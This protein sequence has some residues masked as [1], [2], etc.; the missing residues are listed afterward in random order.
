MSIK[1]ITALTADRVLVEL[2]VGT[3]ITPAGLVIPPV[4]QEIQAH[5]RV[6]MVGPD[7]KNVAVGD[8]VLVETHAGLEIESGRGTRTVLYV[9][10]DI[11]AVLSDLEA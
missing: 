5:G 9:E 7:V 2:T 8:E 11:Q 4:A 3:Q 1:N 10:K 6:L